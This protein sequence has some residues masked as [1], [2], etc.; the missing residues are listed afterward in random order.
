VEDP[1]FTTVHDGPADL[2]AGL[3]VDDV[4]DVETLLMA[5]LDRPVSVAEA[6]N[7]ETDVDALDV[8]IHGDE[9]VAGYLHDFPLSVVELARSGAEVARDLGPY[10]KGSDHIAGRHDVL[11]MGDDD[12]VAALID[13]LGQVR[14][15]N[16][17]DDDE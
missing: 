8:R 5:L 17:L 4:G 6:R 11:S 16:M 13:A 3:D 1:R 12:L 7:D 14:L 10:T 9:Y 15:F 2:L